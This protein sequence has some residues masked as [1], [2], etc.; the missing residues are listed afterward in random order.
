MCSEKENTV[1]RTQKTVKFNITIQTKKLWL[2]ALDLAEKNFWA[3]KEIS[4]LSFKYMEFVL[5]SKSF[6]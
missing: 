6:L 2:L 1:F 5:T 3:F 4:D